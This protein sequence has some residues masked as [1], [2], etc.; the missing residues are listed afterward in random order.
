MEVGSE[1]EVACLGGGGDGDAF[2]GSGRGYWG[3]A[4]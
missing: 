1:G 4:F 2:C 3:M